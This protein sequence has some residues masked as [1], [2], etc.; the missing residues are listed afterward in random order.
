MTLPVLPYLTKRRA[1]AA[2]KHGI[3]SPRASFCSTA[4]R[5]LRAIVTA[6]FIES[7]CTDLTGDETERIPRI[8]VARRHGWLG[9]SCKA[10]CARPPGG[11]ELEKAAKQ[12]DTMTEFRTKEF[13]FA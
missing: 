11:L 3:A 10:T 13:L 12:R 2:N 4:A 7:D 1:G 9:V 6:S 5:S 8:Q